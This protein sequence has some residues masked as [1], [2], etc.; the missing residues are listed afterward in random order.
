MAE[1][2]TRRRQDSTRRLVF[3]MSRLCRA[4]R[5][6]LNARRVSVLVFDSPSETVSFFAS[7]QSEDER[8]RQLA[9]KWSQ[10]PLED[11]PAARAVLIEERPVV[12]E[13]APRDERLP[14]GWAGDFGTTSIHFEPLLARGPVG[15]LA[16]EPASAAQSENLDELVPLVAA[17]A[18]RIP[19]LEE[20]EGR[21]TDADFLVELME[22]AA[23]GESV[24]EALGTICERAAKR[25][26]AR[27][28]AAFVL[29]NGGLVPRA[30]RYAN[31]SRDPEAWERVRT[32]GSAPALAEK[33]IELGV[34]VTAEDAESPLISGWWS[35]SFDIGAALAVPIGRPPN[36][37]GVL[38]FDLPEPHEFSEEET[39]LAASV[40]LRIAA[41]V[42]RARDIEER[43]AHLRA[44]NAVQRLLEEGSRALSAEQAGETL[45]RI[46]KE[47]LDIRH[48]A[49]ILVDS[50]E[51]IQYVGLD[52]PE[53]FESV[54]RERL[55]GSTAREFRLWRRATRE[56]TPIFVENARASQLIP[57][58][59]VTLLELRAYVAFPLLSSERPLGL[60]V[61]AATREGRHWTPEQRRL[62]EQLALEGS[63]VV[64]NAALRGADQER[65]DELARQAFHDPLTE[66]PN[67]ALFA[68]RLEHAL[69]RL[70]RHDQI[71]AVLLLD[72]DGFK[73]VNDSLGHDAGDQ[74]LIA[75]SQRLR[76]ALR[77]ADTIARLGGDEFTILL[78]EITHLGEAT[79][80][81]ERIED[82]L[83]TPFQL[84]G[85]DVRITI[86]IGIALNNATDAQPEDLM[87]NADAAMY[88]AK[89]AGKARYEVYEPG[90]AT[91]ESL[92]SEPEVSIR[93]SIDQSDTDR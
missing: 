92:E 65:I 39:E 84:D 3:H 35:E 21:L 47:A 1:T 32:A 48:A 63:L 36:V 25:L 13:D 93:R 59:L 37:I 60:V 6:A 90:G 88:K 8:V 89:R 43:T 53:E 17:S 42:E 80:V 68:D 83:R 50:E 76:A 91:L 81:A 30:A 64:E 73:E 70:Q 61:C 16:I 22:V 4:M 85:H 28:G 26:G 52:V 23:A 14:T 44:A 57:T 46:V 74:L 56:S 10:I 24:G 12:L 31:G 78:E 75:V 40:G 9:A 66:L 82:S 18:G 86:S 20:L 77:P 7:D 33:V 49:V 27:R 19:P 71:V 62:V 51:R 72:L 79:R 55:V 54:A 45:A 11:F 15:I 69:A 38:T 29:E 67:R 87:R 58:E 2:S 34:P 41:I 5:D